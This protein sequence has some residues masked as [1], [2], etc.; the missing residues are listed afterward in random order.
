MIDPTGY[1]R[2]IRN[3]DGSVK[4]IVEHRDASDDERNVREINS[5][6]YVFDKEKLFDG[7]HHVTPDNTQKEYYLTDVFE[8]LWN[9]HLIVSALVAEHEEEIHG[10]NTFEQLEQARRILDGRLT[11]AARN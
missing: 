5:G 10:I 6:I 2:I 3:A 8:Y 11:G 7:L 9:Q 4:R 1:G